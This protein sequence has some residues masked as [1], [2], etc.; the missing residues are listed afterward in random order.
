M[1]HCNVAIRKGGPRG[2]FRLNWASLADQFGSVREMV[3]SVI[4]RFV[5]GHFATA[6][7]QHLDEQLTPTRYFYSRGA[8][9]S[10]FGQFP[11]LR[12]Q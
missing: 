11:N 9:R 1:I 2:R 10:Y 6:M 12:T 8:R 4:E 7:A 5:D 3:G